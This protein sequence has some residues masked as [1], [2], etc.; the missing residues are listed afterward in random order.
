MTFSLR[1]WQ[2]VGIPIIALKAIEARCAR[3]NADK[4]EL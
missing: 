4:R 1:R 2:Y 3:N